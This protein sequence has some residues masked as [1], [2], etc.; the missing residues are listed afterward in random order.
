MV[1]SSRKSNLIFAKFDDHFRLRILPVYM[2]WQMVVRVG[3]KMNAVE[4]F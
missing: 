4:S 1:P 3:R 2:G